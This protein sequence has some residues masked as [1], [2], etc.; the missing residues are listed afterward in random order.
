MHGEGCQLL[1]L[2]FALHKFLVAPSILARFNK[3]HRVF[4]TARFAVQSK[5]PSRKPPENFPSISLVP[6][7]AIIAVIAPAVI[8]V[9]AYDSCGDTIMVYTAGANTV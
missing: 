2:T 3:Q 1:S 7:V 5:L 4:Y 6:E 8:S 9:C